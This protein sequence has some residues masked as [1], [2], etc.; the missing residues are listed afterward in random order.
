MDRQEIIN[1]FNNAVK[2]HQKYQGSYSKVNIPCNNLSGIEDNGQTVRFNQQIFYLSTIKIYQDEIKRLENEIKKLIENREKTIEE[3][4]LKGCY[5][6]NDHECRIYEL[7]ESKYKTVLEEL[8]KKIEYIRST[9]YQS[10]EVGN[11]Y[12]DEFR[13]IL[14]TSVEIQNQIDEVL[15]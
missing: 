14:D 13:E 2:E 11:S 4:L 8:K 9:S 3:T 6:A 12:I 7:K 5:L 1:K 15:K 10:I